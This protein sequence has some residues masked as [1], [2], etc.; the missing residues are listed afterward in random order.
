MLKA[1]LRELMKSGGIHTRRMHTIRNGKS[2]QDELPLRPLKWREFITATVKAA[3][4]FRMQQAWI[5][6]ASG[7]KPDR[8]ETACWL[9]LRQPCPARDDARAIICF[10]AYKR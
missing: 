10:I 8:A 5:L 7:W 3:H 9:C 4:P 6:I 2:A 1:A